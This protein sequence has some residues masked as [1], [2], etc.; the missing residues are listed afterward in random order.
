MGR[1]LAV[2]LALAAVLAVPFALRPR[3]RRGPARDT[4]VVVTPNNEAIRREFE[5]GFESW[6][7]AHTGRTVAVDWRVLGGTSEIARILDGDYLAAFRNLW[8][9]KLGRPWSEAIRA[10]FEDAPLPPGAPPAA[11]EAREAFL[12]SDVGCGID[13]FFG[14]GTYDFDRQAAIGTLVDS[15]IE[16]IHPAWF[17]PE[18]IPAEFEGNPYRDARNRWFGCVTSCY[19]ILSNRDA[20]RR[21]GLPEPKQWSDLADP[22]YLG[23]VALCDPTKSGS[24]AAAFENI[25]QQAMHRRWAASPG[26]AAVRAGWIDGLRLIQAIG[27]NARYFTDDSQKP[28]IDVADGDCAAGLCIDFYGREE[29]EAVRR[30]SG[31]TRL[32]FA[33]PAGG[34]SYSVD[35]IAVLRGAPHPAAAL[36]FLT[37]VLSLDGQKLWAFRP[38]SPGGPRDFALRR[39]PVRKDFYARTDWRRWRSDPGADPYAAVGQLDYRAD[40]TGGLFSEMAFIIRVMC[41]DDHAPLVRAWAAIARAPA[42]RRERALA[43]L[44]D[45][46]AVDYGQA[47]GP[48]ARALDSADPA[49]AVREARILGEGFRRRYAA[50]EAI[51]EG[52]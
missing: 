22:R 48:V 31:S 33:V 25:L 52:R 44:Q 4:V 40:W 18:G 3:G 46:A 14:G 8:T 45:L 42:D 20:L 39:L 34:T 43:V 32:G 2:L 27:A 24:I 49:A 10:A 19:G 50:A 23:Q 1:R 7:R 30:R 13:V 36:A 37:Y 17:G 51:A 12:A 21:L 15:G 38:G 11:R 47:R 5:L 9:G 26:P 41:E 6:Y 35:P 28:E 16:R 29:E